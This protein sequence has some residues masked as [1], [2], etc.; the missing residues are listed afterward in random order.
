MPGSGLLPSEA[1]CVVLQRASYVGDWR[2]APAARRLDTT[3]PILKRCPT[4]NRSRELVL[5]V[6]L[7]LVVALAL[8]VALAAA[9]ANDAPDI[10]R[11]QAS[12]RAGSTTATTTTQTEAERAEE[13]RPPTCAEAG[14]GP[15]SRR[16]T[17]CST[18]NAI[19]TF[20]N[21]SERLRLDAG[22]ARVASVRA[23]EA[24]TPAGRQ[25]N[26]MRVV[27]LLEVTARDETLFEAAAEESPVY[28]NVGGTRVDPDSNWSGTSRF[29]IDEPLRPGESRRGHL[30]FEL[31]GAETEA[32][33]TNGAQLALRLSAAEPVEVGIVRLSAVEPVPLPPETSGDGG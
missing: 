30:R 2:Q 7:A 28:L 5:E 17:T 15:T 29:A 12:S 9:T 11:G 8:G 1:V 26:R 24:A 6:V 21:G 19:L 4:V 33:T 31:A 32:F 20:V 27:V 23:Y 25:R 13:P 18:T 22:T 16:E 3:L 14:V 10:E